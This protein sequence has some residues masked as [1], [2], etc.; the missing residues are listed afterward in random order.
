MGTGYGPVDR[1]CEEYLKARRRKMLPSIGIPTFV[2][3]VRKVSTKTLLKRPLLTL[4]T[5]VDLVLRAVLP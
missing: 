3:G 2:S 5:V 4:D 1:L